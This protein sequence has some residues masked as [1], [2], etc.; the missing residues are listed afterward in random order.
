MRTELVEDA[1]KAAGRERGFL[2][3][4]VFHS[5]HGSVYTSKAYAAL[6]QQFGVRQSMGAIGSNADNALAESFNAALKREPL[7]SRAALPDQATAYRVVFRW[8]NRYNRRRRHCAIG[9]I[10]PNVYKTTACATLTE[11]A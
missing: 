10:T 4:C 9:N 7:E 5:D 2:A 1:L 6:C 8:A 11:A 3:G